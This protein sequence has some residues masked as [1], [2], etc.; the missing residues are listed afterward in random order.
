MITS[1]K[2]LF[3]RVGSWPKEDIAKLAEAM[4]AIES[5]RND[6]HNTSDEKLC[7]VSGA[8]PD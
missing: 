6:E 1:T 4:S 5:W 7:V 8:C 2:K 3:E